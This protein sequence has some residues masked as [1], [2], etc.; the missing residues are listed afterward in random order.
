[1]G[2]FTLL[3]SIAAAVLISGA[4]AQTLNT[5]SQPPVSSMESVGIITDYTPDS[6]LVLDTGTGEP[7]HFKFAQKVE[8]VD[9]DG[10]VIEAAGLRKNLRVRVHYTQ[11]GGDMIIDKVTLAQ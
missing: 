3:C 10:K 11:H 9:A 4:R 7:K 6:A 8:Y 5:T 2:K 1:M